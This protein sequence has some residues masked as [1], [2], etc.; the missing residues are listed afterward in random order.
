MR[1]TARGGRPAIH[2]VVMM[3]ALFSLMAG[4]VRFGRWSRVEGLL[5]HGAS[6]I[7]RSA[8][9]A[10]KELHELASRAAGRESPGRLRELEERVARL[11]I[12]KQRHRE[13]E[14]ENARLRALLDLGQSLPIPSVAASVLSNAVQ[15]PAKTCLINRGTSAGLRPDMAVVNSQGVVGR[16]WTVAAGIAKVQLL[17]DASSGIAVLVQRSRVQGVLVGRGDHLLQLRYVSTLDDL[18]PG[19]LL[20]TSGQDRIYP[21]GLPVGVIA[22]V[23]E[24]V[25]RQRVVTVV[26]RVDFNRLEEVLVLT[27]SESSAQPMDFDP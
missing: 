4:Q 8:D 15:G 1:H 16:T 19:D 22:G 11:E 3:V 5:L 20:L 26:P 9:A 10:A 2:L 23:S 18:E 17:V 21:K 25:S 7:L 14:I 13:Q 27:E 6:P 12:E 24:S